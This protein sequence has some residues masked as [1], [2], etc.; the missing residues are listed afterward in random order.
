MQE[1]TGASRHDPGDVARRPRGVDERAWSTA[2]GFRQPGSP[3]SAGARRALLPVALAALVLTPALAGDGSKRLKPA[4]DKLGTVEK[5]SALPGDDARAVEAGAAIEATGKQNDVDGARAL[6]GALVVPFPNPSAEMFVTNGALAALGGMSS[7]EARGE[8][9]GLLEKKKADARLAIQIAPVVASWN[10]PASATALAAL[11]TQKEERMIIAG[12]KAMKRLNRRECIEPL[13]AALGS[14]A[15]AGGEPLEA[16]GSALVEISG[17]TTIRAAEDWTKWFQTV[18]PDWDPQKKAAAAAGA[19]TVRFGQDGSN[20]FE[21]MEI[22]SKKVVIIL[23]CSGSMHIKNYIREQSE[24]PPPPPKPTGDGTQSRDPAKTTEA[25]PPGGAPAGGGAPGGGGANGGGGNTSLAGPPL[26][27]GVDPDKPGY[28]PKSCSFAQCPGARGHGPP[29]PS[30]DN[31]PVWFNR[32]ER[33]K[34][35]V[36]KAI[37][38]FKP[39]VRFNI[40]TFSTDA[41]QWQ[42]TL[43][44]ADEKGKRGAIEFVKAQR[45]DGFTNALKA[46]DMA[47]AIE[48]ADTFIFVTDGAPTNPAGRPYDPVR[49]RELLDEVKRLNKVRQVKIDVITMAEGHTQFAQGLASENG[50]QYIQVP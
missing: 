13:I 7:P 28:K 21:T 41:R 49:W 37:T 4:L 44:V 10:E 40:V 30:D 25:T 8:V 43:Q 36:Q 26:P 38:M 33:L 47:F 9:R 15:A 32:M 23:D 20:L 18:A 22:R 35:Q 46:I 11:L 45:A 50:G 19:T 12:A 1:V 42:K 17:Q 2:A 6:L 5:D 16:V 48:D 31:L 14:L 29:C 39:S 34:R 3:L 24:P 27:P